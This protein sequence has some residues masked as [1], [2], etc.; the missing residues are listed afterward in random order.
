[1][2]R[3]K[4]TILEQ[5]DRDLDHLKKTLRERAEYLYSSGGVDPESYLLKYPYSLAEVLIVSA[6]RDELDRRMGFLKKHT[7][8]LDDIEN[9]KHF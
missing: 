6:L 2:D 5:V 4:R 3:A 7:A 8:L 9:L 1:M